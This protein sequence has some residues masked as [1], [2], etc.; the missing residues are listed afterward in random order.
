MIAI[1]A[2]IRAD[3]V[4][5]TPLAVQ[6]RIAEN[7]VVRIGEYE[8]IGELGRGGG[9]TAYRA[10]HVGLG[11]EV[12]LRVLREPARGDRGEAAKRFLREA[13]LAASL[14]HAGVVAV[15]ELDEHEGRPFIAMELVEGESLADRLRR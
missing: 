7:D 2:R 8:V 11:R 1:S 6:L 12:A 5:G 13:E 10:R 15:H 9:A 4:P 3:S 14:A